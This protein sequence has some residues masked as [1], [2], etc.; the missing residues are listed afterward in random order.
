[1]EKWVDGLREAK[2]FWMQHHKRKEFQQN[3]SN[4]PHLN[5]PV[6]VSV[7]NEADNLVSTCM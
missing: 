6:C 2:E 1:M 7:H 4:G 3:I 5:E